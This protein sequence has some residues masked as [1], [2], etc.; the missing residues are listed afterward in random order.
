MKPDNEEFEFFEDG[1]RE[2]QGF[3]GNPFAGSN[4]TN[5]VC[6]VFFKYGN[7]YLDLNLTETGYTYVSL[8]LRYCPICGNK[9][10]ELEFD[11]E[12]HIFFKNEEGRCQS[13]PGSI[14]AESSLPSRVCCDF[15]K[16]SNKFV[17]YIYDGFNYL[18]FPINYCPVCGEKRTE[19]KE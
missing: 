9:R 13:L 5:K 2:Y 19:W 18:F 14:F 17:K 7:K 15:M 8:P 6:C 12:D 11:N 1:E 4:I 16:H 3:L 10:I